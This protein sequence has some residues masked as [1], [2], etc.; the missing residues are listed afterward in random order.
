[1][2]DE[3]LRRIFQSCK[4]IAGAGAGALVFNTNAA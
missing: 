1:M 3:E 2:T 4:L